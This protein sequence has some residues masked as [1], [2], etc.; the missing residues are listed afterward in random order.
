VPPLFLTSALLPVPHGFS[1]RQGGVSEGPYA[2]LNLGYSVGDERSRVEQNFQRLAQAAGTRVDRFAAV[3]QVHGDRVLEAGRGPLAANG[4]VGEADALWTSQRDLA[5]GVKTADC[6]PI[7]LVDP[8]RKTVAAVHSGWRG[9]DLGIA[10]RAVETLVGRGSSPARI[11]AAIGPAIRACCY[12]VSDDLAERFRSAFGP[13]VVERRGG[14]PHLDL[15]RAIRSTLEGA[16]LLAKHIDV[17]P[18]CTSCD[19]EEFFSHRRDKGVTGRH[20]SFAICAF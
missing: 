5:V 15:V 12:E 2:S 18:Q 14:A 19:R 10:A 16:G 13:E 17:L 7:L 20:L 3:S 4:V 6:V 1:T 8:D 9:T 11:L